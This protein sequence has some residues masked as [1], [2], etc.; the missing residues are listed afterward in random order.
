MFLGVP[1]FAAGGFAALIAEAVLKVNL[2][3]RRASQRCA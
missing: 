1:A 2:A 3:K